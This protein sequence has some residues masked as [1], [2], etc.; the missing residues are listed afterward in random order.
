MFESLVI[1]II[2][3]GGAG[4]EAPKVIILGLL[5]SYTDAHFFCV[6]VIRVGTFNTTYT[7]PLSSQALNNY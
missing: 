2:N 7:I 3:K 5:I 6:C 4:V 1:I